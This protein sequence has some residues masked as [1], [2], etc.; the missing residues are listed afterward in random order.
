MCKLRVKE[1]ATLVYGNAVL[2]SI[3]IR[4][5]DGWRLRFLAHNQWVRTAKFEYQLI[6]VEN[7]KIC[8]NY[9]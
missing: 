9:K 6:F 3:Q 2:T 8:C 5:T 4:R 1:S 7:R